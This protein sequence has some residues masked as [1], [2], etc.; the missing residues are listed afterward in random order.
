M[1]PSDR[2]QLIEL[3]LDLRL[4]LARLPDRPWTLDN[5]L[6]GEFDVCSAKD[7]ARSSVKITAPLDQSTAQA[8]CRLAD[9]SE[10]LLR[11]SDRTL[12]IEELRRRSEA[13][14][15]CSLP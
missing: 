8:L 9:L 15:S 14:P 10:E 3:L 13:S 4:I 12:L 1:S 5:S 7:R 6:R 11:L 2:R